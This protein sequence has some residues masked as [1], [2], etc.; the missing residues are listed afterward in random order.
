MTLDNFKNFMQQPCFYCGRNPFLKRYA[1]HRTRY[2]KGI[3]T[4]ES[5]YLNGID[6]VNPKKGYTKENCV[7]CCKI[8]NIAKSDL[9]QSEFR[10][11]ICLIYKNFAGEKNG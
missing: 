8:C 6:R 4:D 2:S 9:S 1:Y 3:K 5:G 11:L 7:P 10:N